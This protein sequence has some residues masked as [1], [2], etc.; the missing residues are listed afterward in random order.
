MK[1]IL[2]SLLLL[3]CFA[4]SQDNALEIFRPLEGYKWYAEGQWG[5]GSA[6]KQEVELEFT[7]ED[8]LIKV[9]SK[10]FTNTEQSEFGPR[11]HGIRQYDEQLGKIKFWEF[12]VF[13]G[14][15]EGIVWGEGK[16][17]IYSYDYG[18]TKL[19]EKWVYKDDNTYAFIVGVFEN[20]GWVQK[21]LETEFK[22]KEKPE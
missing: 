18:G 1:H 8:N 21:F 17:I 7:L 19:T 6:F 16:D 2:I 3:P 5:D 11:N 20:N 14:L 4:Q 22:R 9:A 13:G 10:G 12:D 15:T